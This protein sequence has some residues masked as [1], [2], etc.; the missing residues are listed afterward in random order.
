MA[1]AP[2]RLAAARGASLVLAGRRSA[3]LVETLAAAR[4]A[5][6]DQTDEAAV[7]S[8]AAGCGPLDGM[9]LNAGEFEVGT[10]AATPT[11]LFDRML[12][13]NLRGPW[14]LCHHLA[15]GL[16]PGASV[17]LIGSNL[18]M[19]AIPNAAAYSV[20][21]AG[22]HMLAR[23]LAVEW[24]SRGIRCNAIAPGPVRTPMLEDRFRDAPDPDGALGALA[25]V[26]P[27]H[28]LGTPD[29]VAALVVHL[30]ADESAWTTGTIIPCDGGAVGAF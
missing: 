20:A 11:S 5:S 21:K 12:S 3:P 24:A 4:H 17:V 15:D 26:N 28:R 30:L 25:T 16:N 9:V 13:A 2:A 27:L 14:L 19:R 8:F 22:L 23:V 29:D 10:V 6:L 18:G 1:R 7:A